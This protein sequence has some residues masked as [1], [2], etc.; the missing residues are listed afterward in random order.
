MRFIRRCLMAAS[1]VLIFLGSAQAQSITI[2]STVVWGGADS[3]NGNLLVAQVAKLS[4]G[5]NHPEPVLLRHRRQRK[6]D[7][8]NI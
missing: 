1:Y 8:G 2:G 3:G 6:S 4:P 5:R 7:H